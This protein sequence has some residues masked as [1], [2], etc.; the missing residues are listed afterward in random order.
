[1]LHQQVVVQ[2]IAAPQPVHHVVFG[3]LKHDKPD[4][5]LVK[6]RDEDF[7][8]A[9]FGILHECIAGFFNLLLSV[10]VEVV[11]QRADLRKKVWLQI[12]HLRSSEKRRPVDQVQHVAE[13]VLWLWRD[14][15]ER[16]EQWCVW[17]SVRLG[18]DAVVLLRV[19][20]EGRE[21]KIKSLSLVGLIQ[22][23]HVDTEDVLG[24][25]RHVR[26]PGRR[27]GV[28]DEETFLR[29]HD[30]RQSLS[31]SILRTAR[32][33]TGDLLIGPP[34]DDHGQLSQQVLREGSALLFGERFQ[35]DY[36][37]QL[38]SITVS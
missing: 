35:E 34:V 17:S 36:R 33:G 21:Q 20:R 23:A 30:L 4:D 22:A 32:Q 18:D 13:G 24:V 7:D 31:E 16:V 9:A 19:E 28:T 25:L 37:I 15:G 5:L 11:N 1:M 27:V 6:L 12:L 26:Q 2:M 38:L 3:H 29:V 10:T 8:I 14:D